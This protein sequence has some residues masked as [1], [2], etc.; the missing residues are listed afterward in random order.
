MAKNF[1]WTTLKAIFLNILIFVCVCV[2][3]CV[4]SFSR[5]SNRPNIVLSEQYINGEL[6]YLAFGE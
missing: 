1:I 2:C 4:P 5:F 6:I 3:V